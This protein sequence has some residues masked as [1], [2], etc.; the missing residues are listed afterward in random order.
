M[1]MTMT[2]AMEMATAGIAAGVGP[3]GLV[4]L[5]SK[6][7]SRFSLLPTVCLLDYM[8]WLGEDFCFPAQGGLQTEM[9][10]VIA[11]SNMR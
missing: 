4:S 9:A 8:G 3:S 1:A 6:Q 11:R 10:F 5:A 7:G 2:M